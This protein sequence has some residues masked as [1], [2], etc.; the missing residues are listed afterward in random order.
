MGRT[1]VVTYTCDKCHNVI[2]P[3]N[4]VNRASVV[5]IIHSGAEGYENDKYFCNQCFVEVIKILHDIG[6]P[7]R[8]VFPY[9]RFNLSFITEP[10]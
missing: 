5:G 6:F 1:T 10:R 2:P 9:N 4:N 8:I 3:N 7:Q